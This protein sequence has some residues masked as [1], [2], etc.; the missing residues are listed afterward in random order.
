MEINLLDP[1]KYI[2]IVV[3]LEGCTAPQGQVL[4]YVLI[5]DRDIFARIDEEAEHD[6]S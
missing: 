3:P 5:N 2:E 6:Q 4:R 1:P